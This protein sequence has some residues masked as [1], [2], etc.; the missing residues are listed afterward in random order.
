MSDP[1]LRST[2]PVTL[3]GGGEA[4]SDLLSEALRHA[5]DLVCADGGADRALAAGL[6]PQAVIGDL[7]SISAQ[8]RAAVPPERLH[9]IPEQDST[10]FDK[11]LRHIAAPLVLGVGFLGG[12]VDHE[13]AAFSTLV[14]R[15][16]RPCVLLGARDVICAAPPDCTLAV[17]EGTRVSLYP[18]ARVAGVSQGLRW[19]IEG[20]DFAPDR[21]I[22]TSNMAAAGGAVRLRFDAPGMLL[23]LPRRCL[24]VMMTALLHA[25]GWR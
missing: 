5:P 9:P 7:D 18:L 4:P 10:D 6:M 3:L 23:I 25:P 13:L 12:R 21:R 19:P 22:G 17:A 15:C 14:T 11:C 8:A 24:T 2:A 16:D 1:I 20:L